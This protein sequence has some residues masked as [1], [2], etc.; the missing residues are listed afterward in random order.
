[1][2]DKLVKT[3]NNNINKLN[4]EILKLENDI[5]AYRRVINVNVNVLERIKYV[6]DQ[7]ASY[8][9]QKLCDIK[10]MEEYKAYLVRTSDRDLYPSVAEFVNGK[11]RFIFGIEKSNMMFDDATEVF[12]PKVQKKKTKQPIKD[13][14]IVQEYK[15]A[16]YVNRGKHLQVVFCGNGLYRIGPKTKFSEDLPI[17][18]TIDDIIE[19]TKRAII[20]N[21]H[22][23]WKNFP[24]M[25]TDQWIKLYHERMKIMWPKLTPVERELFA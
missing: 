8:E 12:L 18:W 20:M 23:F 10:K 16:H 2:V 9:W 13:K 5:K 1:M 15:D 7:S 14:Q 21:K 6:T 19:N 4:D 11:L 24:D 25:D 17:R 22:G 3:L